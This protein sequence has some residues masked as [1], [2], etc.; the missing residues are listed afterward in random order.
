VRVKGEDVRKGRKGIFCGY[1]RDSKAYKVWV[2]S[3]SDYEFTADVTWDERNLQPLLEAA[4]ILEQGENPD[5]HTNPKPG[6]SGEGED[7]STAV[8]AERQTLGPNEDTASISTEV[9]AMTDFDTWSEIAM[10]RIGNFC[11]SVTRVI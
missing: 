2:I 6:P 7:V 9:S 1:I 11:L 4:R 8:S 10:T 3:K 5:F